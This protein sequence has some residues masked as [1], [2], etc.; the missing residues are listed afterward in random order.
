MGGGG[1]TLVFADKLH[2][3]TIPIKSKIINACNLIVIC[4]T[5]FLMHVFIFEE[6]KNL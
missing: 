2:M 3:A 4:P 5:F 6:K 1:P